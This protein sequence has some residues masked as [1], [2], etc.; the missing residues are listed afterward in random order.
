MI[1]I[2]KPLFGYVVC[3]TMADGA[4]VGGALVTDAA[5]LPVEFRHTEPVV[6]SRI[7]RVLYG[8]VLE[9]YM[10]NDVVVGLLLASLTSIPQMFIVAEVNYLDGAGAFGQPAVWATDARNVPAKE[11]GTRLDLSDEEYVLHLAPGNGPIRV[12]MIHPKRS[13]PRRGSIV[14]APD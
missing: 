14:E 1:E 3:L 9:A 10:H 8:R 5:G 7:Q 13:P 12:R 4:F 11:P 6:P 2:G